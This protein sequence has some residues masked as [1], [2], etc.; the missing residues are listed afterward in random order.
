MTSL[1][2]S[3]NLTVTSQFLSMIIMTIMNL[4]WYEHAFVM[5][6]MDIDYGECEYRSI[7]LQI[8][9]KLHI[10]HNFKLNI[11]L[12]WYIK[13]KRLTIDI[14]IMRVIKV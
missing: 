9:R 13:Y 7:L 2:P 8:K 11:Y 1:W 4:L 12:I 10:F 6:N 14:C 5:W 3:D